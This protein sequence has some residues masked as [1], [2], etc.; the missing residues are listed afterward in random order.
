MA[1]RNSPDELSSQLALININDN[2]NRPSKVIELAEFKKLDQILNYKNNVFLIDWGEPP[3]IHILNENFS[4]IKSISR[5]NT[6]F[7]W[8]NPTRI[9]NSEYLAALTNKEILFLDENFNWLN[10]TIDFNRVKKSSSRELRCYGL[11]QYRDNL[12]ILE[13]KQKTLII[14]SILEKMFKE[15]PIRLPEK[16]K[17]PYLRDL[18]FT[19]DSRFYLN[20][21]T[22]QRLGGNDCIHEFIYNENRNDISYIKTIGSDLLCGPYSLLIKDNLLWV[23]ERKSKGS[24]KCFDICD[25]FKLKK[26]YNLS[27]DCEYPYY[28]AEVNEHVYITQIFGNQ[29][30]YHGSPKI[31]KFDFNL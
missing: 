8:M 3:C 30:T 2:S 26:E 19:E 29:I 6:Y 1:S 12:F 16:F 23:C 4:Y 10:E 15:I 18:K 22:I 31:F 9:F 13:T 20:D 11:A 14:Y 28:F 24:L 27:T 25:G 21:Y 7:H 17:R 5:E